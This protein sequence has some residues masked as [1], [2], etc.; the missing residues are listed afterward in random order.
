MTRPTVS[1]QSGVTSG[2]ALTIPA[3]TR[4][5]WVACHRE[6][7]HA[8]TGV[9]IGGVA[10]T[11]DNAGGETNAEVGHDLHLCTWTLD[12]YAAFLARS[13]DVITFTGGTIGSVLSDDNYRADV[14]YL[15]HPTHTVDQVA[16]IDGSPENAQTQAIVVSLAPG[17]VDARALVAAT[18][19]G[20]NFTTGFAA[21]QTTL[22]GP[23]QIDADG[24]GTYRY[25]AHAAITGTTNV[26]M[27]SGAGANPHAAMAASA[28]VEGVVADITLTQDPMVIAIVMPTQ[29]PITD[30]HVR[31]DPMVIEVSMPTQVPRL[32]IPRQVQLV[33]GKPATT[34]RAAAAD[35]VSAF[36][37]LWDRAHLGKEPTMVDGRTLFAT[38]GPSASLPWFDVTAYGATGDG[39]TDD[40]TAISDAIV[41]LTAAGKG[42]LYF[43]AGTYK[44]SGG[45]TLSVPCTVLGDG[46]SDFGDTMS[47]SKITCTSQTAVL[48]T[49]TTKLA[50]FE[51]LSL[52][53]TFAGTPSAG[54]AIF[55]N[56]SNPLARIDLFNVYVQGF[57]DNFDIAVAGAFWTV[58]K[59]FIGGAVRYGLRIRNTATADF[60]DPAIS[61][62]VFYP[63]GYNGTAA[64]RIE[65]GGGVK[66]NNVKVNS[67]GSTKWVDAV[68]LVGTGATSILLVSNSSFENYSGDGLDLSG[69]WRYQIITGCEFGQYGNATGNAI[70][71][72]SNS[73]VI[74]DDCAFV[75][76]TGTPTAISISS[77]TRCAVGIVT[78]NGFATLISGTPDQD[79][80]GSVGSL[81]R[82]TGTPSAGQV[83]VAVSGTSAP[84][85]TPTAV[86]SFATPA[87]ALGAAAAA[88][89]A[90]TVIRSDSTIAAFDAT[91]PTTQAIGDSAAVGS[92]AFAA[93]RDHKHGMPAFGSPVAVGTAN[94]DGSAATVPRSDHVHAGAAGAVDHAHV[95]SEAH[96]SDGAT[97]A[98]TLDQYFESGSV[99]A[100]N[101]TTI[102]RLTVTETEP[103]SATVSPVGT[104]GDSIVFDYAATVA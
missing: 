50:R 76:D 53:N 23:S 90:S 3:N 102:A 5:L 44:T 63:I 70:K 96:L 65:S 49:V 8:M 39:S 85:T 60:G 87:V 69:T 68:S 26:G 17:A 58:D 12:D 28:W 13:S 4:G 45:F 29:T 67:A 14:Y 94:A 40:T 59:C 77:V 98:Y 10:L 88:G 41:A 25:G 61:D 24:A 46:V 47:V 101:A 2:G 9:S 64:I 33:G 103:D 54:S 71:L 74:I 83:P 62:S 66:I 92:A 35:P 72:A 6:G 7:A 20:F 75:A 80:T 100:W 22:Y 16:V 104:A 81:V 15:I 36:D 73:D 52:I 32:Y 97:G 55:A 11:L 43:P 82:I 31:Q 42:V 27:N 99:I 1:V 89:A 84:W 19:N 78:N 21:G 56:C 93:R 48:F 57:R 86:P 79:H 51:G 18:H 34:E 38:G 30:V 95:V 37:I 91:S